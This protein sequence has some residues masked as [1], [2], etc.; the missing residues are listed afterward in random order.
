MVRRRNKQK[1]SPS[2]SIPDDVKQTTD[3]SQPP[4]VGWTF[5]ENQPPPD[6]A[7]TLRSESPEPQPEPKPASPVPQP[8]SPTFSTK[9]SNWAESSSS[10]DE[11]GQPEETP[12]V[13]ATAEEKLLELWC[14]VEPVDLA[15][16]SLE[17]LRRVLS[18]NTRVSGV[19]FGKNLGV[20]NFSNFPSVNLKFY[21]GPK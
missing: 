1:A 11:R 8:V 10:E 9:M 21:N 3:W 4:N 16:P 12:S 20:V 6:S 14:K 18:L 15:P 7:Q 5:G 13:A 17:D 2:P 19:C